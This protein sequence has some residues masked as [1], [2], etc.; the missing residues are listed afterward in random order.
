MK[1]RLNWLKLC[2]RRK[3][4]ICIPSYFLSLG[5]NKS[6]GLPQMTLVQLYG[7]H[8]RQ[9]NLTFHIHIDKL[10]IRFVLLW[11]SAK[12]ILIKNDKLYFRQLY[13]SRKELLTRTNQGYNIQSCFTFLY[14]L[15]MKVW[16]GK[17]L[18]WIFKG[19][20]HQIFSNYWNFWWNLK[21]DIWE[22]S[23]FTLND[24][25]IGNGVCNVVRVKQD[26]QVLHKYS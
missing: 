13:F 18:A 2:I 15:K 26:C 24:K 5:Q 8:Y 21:E 16:K 4:N 9:L 11:L 19:W 17:N 14:N 20:P 10:N 3:C 1:W 7:K 25:F 12:N 6:R 22:Y 23:Q